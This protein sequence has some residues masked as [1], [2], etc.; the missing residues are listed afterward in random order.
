M[1]DLFNRRLKADPLERDVKWC[2]DYTDR[3]Q[4]EAWQRSVRA[5]LGIDI[6]ADFFLGKEYDRMLDV[7]A[8]TRTNGDAVEGQSMQA[9]LTVYSDVELFPAEPGQQSSGDRLF[10]MGHWYVCKSAVYWG[11]TMLKHWIAEFEGVEGEGE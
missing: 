7:Q 10:Y 6:R 5:T 2:A 1:R 9:K 8:K 3:R 11:N 4:L